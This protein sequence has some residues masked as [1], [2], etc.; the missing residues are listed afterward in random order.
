MS[1]LENNKNNSGIKQLNQISEYSENFNNNNINDNINSQIDSNQKES[2]DEEE[3]D[4]D[5]EDDNNISEKENNNEENEEGESEEID[6]ENLSLLSLYKYRLNYDD[7]I[8]LYPRPKT[9]YLFYK[10]LN[11][12]NNFISTPNNIEIIPS[13][14]AYFTNIE[15]SNSSIKLIRPSQ[16]L[17]P[18]NL[19]QFSKTLNLFGIN[20]EPFSLDEKQTSIEFIQKINVNCDN[21]YNKII[22]RCTNCNAFYHKLNFHLELISDNKLYHTKKYYCLICKRYEKFFTVDD[23]KDYEYH[24]INKDIDVNKIFFVPEIENKKPSIEYIIRDENDYNIIKNT[25]QIII[26]DLSNKDFVGFIYKTL[27]ELIESNGKDMENSNKNEYNIKY[28]LIVYYYNKIYFLYLNQISLTISVS[29][30]GDLQNPFC[31]VEPK[32][33]F[34]SS[35]IFLELLNIFYNT[36]LSKEFDKKNTKVPLNFSDINNCI[37][38]SIFHLI[39]ENRINEDINQN[40]KYYYHLIF[41]SSFNHNINLDIFK[42][43]KI[44]NIFLSFFLVQQKANKNIP[45]IDNLNIHNIKLYY[46]PI[47]YNENDDIIQKYQKIKIVLNKI[48][49]VKNYIYEVKLNICYDRKLFHNYNNTNSIYISFIPNKISL[50]KIYILPQIGRPILFSSIFFQFNIEYYTLLDKYK[51]IRILT[52]MNKVSNDPEEVFKSFDEDVIFRIVLANHIKELNLSKYNFNSINKLY[53]DIMNKNDKIFSKM[54]NNILNQI[55]CIFAKFYK[56]GTDNRGIFTPISTKLFPLYF[57]SFIKQ[58][59]NGNNLNLLNLLYDCK[60][61]SFIKSIYPNLISFGYK[62]KTNKEFFH[63]KSLSFEFFDKS[64][65][66]LYDDGLFITLFVNCDIKDK[67]KDHYLKN[68]EDKDKIYLKAESEVINDIIKNKNIKIVFLNDNIIFNNNFLNI[69]LE[70]RIIDNI[71]NEIDNESKTE[72]DNIY[73]QNDINYQDFY[74]IIIQNMYEFFE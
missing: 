53:T 20:I 15:E 69:F 72:I 12:E 40:N 38:K 9:Y 58:I 57:F 33:L 52:F 49:N 18:Y 51:H 8:E 55:K 10:N 67:V 28:V 35:K 39:K 62:I 68:V 34:C 5:N 25:I 26:L 47:Q 41:F 45:F 23:S 17:I 44:N 56:I 50:N 74:Q 19:S 13:V 54:I 24:I 1:L 65:L 7:R 66:L 4:E 61:K 31:P 30:M 59:S 6:E 2:E 43:N 71:N 32:K 70:D 14:R 46:F 22:L 48:L 60:I 21:K 73:I 37:I 3:E 16:Y 36:F 27:Y 29:I 63:I 11:M 42:E 64:Q